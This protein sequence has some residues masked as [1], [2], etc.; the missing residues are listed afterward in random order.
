MAPKLW[1]ESNFFTIVFFLDILI[2]PF[3]RLDDN[4]TGSK[5]G[6]IPIAIAT[7]N[8]NDINI[9][10]F[11]AFNKNTIG[12]KIINNSISNISSGISI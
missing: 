10:C 8:V 7:A 11:H 4:I 2:A 12:I 1:I 6:V 3:D 5:R 9:L